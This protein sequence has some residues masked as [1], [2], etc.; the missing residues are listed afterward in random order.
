MGAQPFVILWFGT[1]SGNVCPKENNNQS[2][3]NYTMEKAW[4]IENVN[5]KHSFYAML[6]VNTIVEFFDSAYKGFLDSGVI[7]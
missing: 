3:G 1:S 4:N 5:E 7:E 2:T 6:L